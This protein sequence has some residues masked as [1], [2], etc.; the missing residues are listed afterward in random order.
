MG[1]F[2]SC[3]FSGKTVS[4]KEHENRLTARKGAI[5]KKTMKRMTDSRCCWKRFDRAVYP[6][7]AGS[8]FWVQSVS[9]MPRWPMP[10]V[11][12]KSPSFYER[13]DD[14]Y[15]P[16]D[17]NSSLVVSGLGTLEESWSGYALQRSGSEV[18]P[19]VVPALSSAGYTNV[20]CDTGGVLRFWLKPYWSSSSQTGGAGPGATATL[21]ELDAVNG[22]GS[23]LAW[24]LQ[25][26]AD[27]NTLG[28]F[29]VTDSGLQ[30][31]LQS[32]ISWQ[33]G[34]SYLVT[35]DYGPDGTTLFVEDSIVA[36]GSGV[37]SVP[38]STGQLVLG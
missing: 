27:G 8:L 26:S 37:P 6:L 35:L 11:P 20:S 2:C 15:F 3:A 28:L 30:E 18:T 10:P 22:V 7:V 4:P 32:T 16:G 24:S 9:A 31:V 1:L 38:L 19:F 17:T 23:A 33:A 13:F 21:L 25:I 29:A 34:V 14:Y 5:L 12:G 36:E